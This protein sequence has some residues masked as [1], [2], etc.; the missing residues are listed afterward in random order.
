M[1]LSP[2]PPLSPSGRRENWALAGRREEEVERRGWVEKE[3]Q[4]GRR[5][6]KRIALEHWTAF[7]RRAVWRSPDMQR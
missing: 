2:P 6:S 1:L 7:A 3:E 5:R 4:I